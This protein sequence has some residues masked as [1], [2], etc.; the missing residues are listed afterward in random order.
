M[1]LLYQRWRNLKESWIRKWLGVPCCPNIVAL[2][3]KGILELPMTSL[4]DLFKCDQ[5]RPAWRLLYLS[6]SS[7]EHCSNSENMEEVEY[8]RRGSVYS[9]CI[10]GI[11]LGRYRV[12]EQGLKINWKEFWA[13]NANCI[14]LTVRAIYSVLPIPQNLNLPQVVYGCWLIKI[15]SVWLTSLTQGHYMWRQS[16]FK[17]I[18]FFVWEY[19]SWG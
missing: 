18:G 1:K 9:R 8:T 5:K 10:I 15:Y 11:S 4:V 6:L 12:E 14:K 2:Y 7:Q 17:I 19:M 16:G 13:M 3:G